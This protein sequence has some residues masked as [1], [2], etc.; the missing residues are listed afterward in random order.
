[1]EIKRK[2]KEYRSG[3]SSDSVDRGKYRT[4]YSPCPKLKKYWEAEGWKHFGQ[5]GEMG[6]GCSLT[7]VLFHLPTETIF[8]WIKSECMYGTSSCNLF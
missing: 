3:S 1:M 4:V 5:L 6:A 7:R 8:S 2:K